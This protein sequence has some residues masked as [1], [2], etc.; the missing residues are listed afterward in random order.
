MKLKY[1]DILVAFSEIPDEISLCINISQCPHRCKGCH[2]PYLQTD[3]GEDLTDEVLE[4]TIERNNGIT[5]V[6]I[7]GGDNNLIEVQH[8]SDV[9]HKHNLKAAWYSGLDYNL[10]NGVVDRQI[11]QHFDYVKTGPYIESRGP[12]TSK[13]TNQRL[14]KRISTQPYLFE[15]ITNRF[16]K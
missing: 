11:Y 9:I 10:A 16:W 12:L 1:V 14:Y 8:I 15:D 13:T 6:C 4:S 5:C 3:T 7:M 2:S